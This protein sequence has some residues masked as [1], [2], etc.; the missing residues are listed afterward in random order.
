MGRGPAVSEVAG[1]ALRWAMDGVPGLCCAG[2]NVQEGDPG[3]EEQFVSLRV[4]GVRADRNAPSESS[5]P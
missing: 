1:R 4:S 5:G 2:V 3:A